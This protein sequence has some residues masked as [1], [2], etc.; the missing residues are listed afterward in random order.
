MMGEAPEL[1]RGTVDEGE[2]RVLGANV[3]LREGDLGAG[4]LEL[5]RH[6]LA[7]LAVAIAESHPRA[8][9]EETPDRR[10]ADPGCPAGHR[11]DLAVEP[12]HGPHLSLLCETRIHDTSYPSGRYRLVGP[13]LGVRP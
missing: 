7:A 11:Y 10:L 9:G 12:S 5:G 1:L 8:L 6:A 3:S 2:A 4:G 13:G